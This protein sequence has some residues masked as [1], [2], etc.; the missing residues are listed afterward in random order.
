MM[1]LECKRKKREPYENYP[2]DDPHRP[3]WKI[4]KN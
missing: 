2:K 1:G 3:R 4:R